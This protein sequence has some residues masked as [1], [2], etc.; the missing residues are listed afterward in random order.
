M[1]LAA[2]V[3]QGH[4]LMQDAR[5]GGH[6]LHR[7]RPKPATIAKA[8]GMLDRARQHICDGLDPAMGM[9]RKAVAV[10]HGVVVAEIIEQQERVQLGRVLEAKGAVQMHACPLHRGFGAAGF[11]NGADRHG[12][13]TPLCLGV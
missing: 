10:E 3:A 12:R 7:S 2:R 1:H 5:S 9:P 8:V 4:F 13:S 6:P 11:Q